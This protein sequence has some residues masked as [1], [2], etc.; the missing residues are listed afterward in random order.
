MNQKVIPIVSIAAGIMAFFLTL[1]YLR[2]KEAEVQRT[3]DEL[4]RSHR[5]VSV[6][7]ALVDI[8]GG[9]TL[10]TSDLDLIPMVEAT[11][12]EQVIRKEDGRQLLGKKTIFQIRAGRAILWSDLE[13]GEP[14]GRGLS[15]MVTREQRAV[16]IAVSGAA[17]VSGMV[18]PNDH[19]DVLGTFAFPSKTVPGE[20][21]SATLTIL[22]DV[23]VLATGQEIPRSLAMRRAG[24]RAGGSYSTVTLEVTP[25]EAELLVFAQQTQGR[26]SLTLRN[27]GD[28]YFEKDL[29]EVDFKVLESQLPELNLHRQ[30]KLR[31]R[32]NL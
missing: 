30:R 32:T 24:A 1:K 11:A 12:P 6:V 19:V 13:G 22:Q 17:A 2:D 8:P 15:S 20:M 21:E 7:A 10:K 18:E 26:L 16:S 4:Y 3:K 29:P 28:V 23:T 5:T 27:P 25:R 9:T 14:L 31:M